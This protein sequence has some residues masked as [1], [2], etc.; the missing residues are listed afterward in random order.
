VL[1]ALL[2]GLIGMLRVR[3]RHCAAAIGKPFEDEQTLRRYAAGLESSPQESP[4]R[5]ALMSN[6]GSINERK[7]ALSGPALPCFRDGGFNQ[8][9]GAAGARSLVTKH[10]IIDADL[11]IKPI[12]FFPPHEQSARVGAQQH[13]RLTGS[14][15]LRLHFWLPLSRIVAREDRKRAHVSVTNQ[16]PWPIGKQERL[17]RHGAIVQLPRTGLHAS[18]NP[19]NGG[20][21]L[22]QGAL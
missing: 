15:E 4:A 5:V 3:A 6:L 21:P 14:N 22:I 10:C 7:E 17:F 20:S 13:N 11:T 19:A 2:F 1:S 12:P 8:I 9:T 18:G 16:N